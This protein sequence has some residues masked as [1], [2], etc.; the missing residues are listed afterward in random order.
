MKARNTIKDVAKEAD[1]AIS[2]VSRVLNSS[3]Y[4]SEKTRKKVLDAVQILSY[5]Q[6]NVARSLRQKNSNF[7]GLLVPDIANEFY[8][9]LAKVIERELFKAGFH[10]FLCNTEENEQIES[11]I[12]DAMLNN[13]VSGLIIIGSGEK[14]NPKL[15]KS[16]IPTV[17]FD[18]DINRQMPSN[19]VFVKSD[20]YL[21]AS[22]ATETLLKKGCRRIAMIRTNHPSVPMQEREMAFLDMVK[23]Y[24]IVKR[25]YSVYSVPISSQA[26]LKKTEEVFASERFDG[27]FCAA[28]IL[29]IGVIKAL[30]N[31]GL[32][33]PE[34]VQII[35]FDD[36]P[37][38]SFLTPTLSTIHS[39][40]EAI[41]CTITSNIIKLHNNQKTERVSI[42][43]I[44]YIERES[45]KN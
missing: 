25:N 45:T 41:G 10:L 44:R 16:D 12:I 26:A 11:D 18:K 21:G 29:A 14:I 42:L 32:H 40:F 22:V 1:V 43:P 5:Q 23:K 3:G 15:L 7:I 13:Q 9:S 33:I 6:N 8:S 28:D 24:N 39:D 4:V 30:Q 27:I 35:S 2:T 36:I 37:L 20:N 31:M 34:D 19:I 38:A 17:F